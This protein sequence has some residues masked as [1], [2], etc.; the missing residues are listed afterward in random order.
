VTA[1][2]RAGRIVADEI[3]GA[4]DLTARDGDIAITGAGGPINADTTN[5]R[6]LIEDST[7]PRVTAST[8]NGDIELGL[9]EPQSVE[10]STINGDILID[11][12]PCHPYA[13]DIDTTADSTVS[14]PMD[15]SSPRKIRA[16]TRESVIIE[17]G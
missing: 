9:T 4:L 12:G 2:N 3:S 14:V 1:N 15:A 13:V 5:G 7:S 17:C 16:R 11:L 6:V 8:R 10:A